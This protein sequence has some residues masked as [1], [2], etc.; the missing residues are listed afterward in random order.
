[1]PDHVTQPLLAGTELLQLYPTPTG[2]TQAL[3]GVDV[4]IRTGTLTAIT[5]PS[6]SGKSTLLA[7][8][9]LRERPAGGTLRHRGSPVAALS[10][11]QVQRLRRHHIGYIAQ[12]PAHGLFPQLSA[13]RQIEQTAWLRGVPVDPVAVLAD[14]GL[15]ERAD[16]LP[17]ALSG[18]EQQRLAVAAA[19]VG[20]PD[21]VIADEPTA[22][23]DDTTAD[24]VLARLRRCA[25]QGVAVVLATHDARAVAVADAVLH[26]RHGVLSAEQHGAAGR[27]AA[28]DG[29]GRVQLPEPA[30][31]LFPDG[32]ALVEVHADHVR[33][34]PPDR[35]TAPGRTADE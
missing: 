22:E 26:L 7:I 34:V 31:A 35:P 17:A 32:R 5:G 16:A 27:T 4:Q 8:L 20:P 30:L 28:I 18:G 21:L 29:F 1:M 9:A 11:R 24:L 19:C 23:L 12:R 13:R 6:G 3:R 2:P 33:L 14:V 25:E 10:R 15:V